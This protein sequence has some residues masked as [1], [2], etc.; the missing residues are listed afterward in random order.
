MEEKR[1]VVVIAA[2]TAGIVFGIILRIACEHPQEL[3][4][5]RYEEI[6]CLIREG[7]KSSSWNRRM[8]EWLG[9]KGAVFHYGKWINPV[10]Y[11]CLKILTALLGILALGK[12]SAGCAI[13]A[14][15]LLYLLPDRMLEWLN[16]QDNRAML[17]EIKLIYHALE[18]QIRAGVYI[19]DALAECYARVR[20]KR[21]QQALLEL[22]G[23]LV[24]KSDLYEALENFQKKFDNRQIDSL[25]II[26]L[27]AC[28]SGQAVEI[29]R[30]I[31]EQLKDMEMA[32]MNNRRNALD[33]SVTFYQ[34]GILSAVL[35]F[36]IY[37]C[38][39]YMF[40][41]AVNL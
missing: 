10:R 14:A 1:D 17:P 24:M 26:L 21:L 19:S 32:A 7:R 23:S 31:G 20:G 38:V 40:S 13:L 8:E 16:K 29:L 11:L 28:E 4:L 6:S 12:I 9:R 27:Q 30:D 15:L 34:L 41:S 3:V 35:G 2:V 39:S 37:V 25:C 36:I 5:R 18:I 33:R 22:S